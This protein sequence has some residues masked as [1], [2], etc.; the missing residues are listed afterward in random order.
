MTQSELDKLIEN[1]PYH[2]PRETP[3]DAEIRMYLRE[4]EYHCPLCGKELQSR[5]QKKPSHKEFQI[6]HI[7]PNRPTIQQYAILHN[8]ERLGNTS[9]DYENKIALCHL[10]HSRQDYYTTKDDYEALLFIKKKYL[11]KSALHDAIDAL[12]LEKELKQIVDHICRIQLSELSKLNMSP[13]RI[14]DKFEEAD[15]LI[16]SKITGYVTQYYTY[17]RDLFREQDGKNGFVFNAL[18]L[19]V[20]AAFFKMDALT[21]DKE[22]IFLQISEWI[23]RKTH[24]I[25]QTACEAVA[26]FFVQN[27]EVFNEIA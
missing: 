10:C 23:K 9:E 16:L 6:A 13:V 27:C 1:D 22:F 17:I 18:C 12:N 20:R 4:V 14:A 7:Y 26:A 24:S 2:I 8:L 19:E 15:M 5:N 21:K 3:N 25:S 11:E